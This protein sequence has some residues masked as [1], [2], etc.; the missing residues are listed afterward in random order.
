MLVT[1]A[2]RDKLPLF[3]TP[4]KL[5]AVQRSLFTAAEDSGWRLQAWAL[6]ANHVHFVVTPDGPTVPDQEPFESAFQA[7]STAAVNRE[8]GTKGRSVWFRSWRTRLTFESSFLARVS[9]VH[10]NAVRHGL[11]EQARDYPWCSAMW[12]ED[13]APKPFARKVMGLRTDR[14][15]V[16]D[17]F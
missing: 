3:G 8:E 11:V 15:H 2:T 17:D 12:F 6:F 1:S 5:A 14:V 16:V 13:T 4:E 9:Y 7:L 10:N